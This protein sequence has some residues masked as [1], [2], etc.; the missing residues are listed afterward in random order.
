MDAP[1]IITVREIIGMVE[2]FYSMRFLSTLLSMLVTPGFTLLM[3]LILEIG[4][5][6]YFKAGVLM[7]IQIV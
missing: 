7:F 2:S 4:L 3:L 5:Y 6:K 1:L